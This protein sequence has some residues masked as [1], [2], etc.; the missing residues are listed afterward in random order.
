[1]PDEAKFYGYMQS[2]PN[3]VHKTILIFDSFSIPYEF[4]GET[5]VKLENP[6]KIGDITTSKAWYSHSNTTFSKTAMADYQTSEFQVSD[7]E[8]QT[9]SANPESPNITFTGFRLSDGAN[10]VGTID[11]N[12]KITIDNVADNGEQIINLIPLN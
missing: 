4:D 12:D 10:V 7:Y 5:C 3:Y 6:V 9:I 8:I 11:E 1:M 2:T